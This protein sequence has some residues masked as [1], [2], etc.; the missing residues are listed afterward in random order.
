MKARIKGML[1]MG[2]LVEAALKKEQDKVGVKSEWTCTYSRDEI[3]KIWAKPPGRLLMPDHKKVKRLLE[4]YNGDFEEY[5]E[6][7]KA[8]EMR[9]KLAK[10]R[11]K[12]GGGPPPVDW[13]KSGGTLETDIDLRCREVQKEMDRAA[14]NSNPFMDSAVL[15]AA[16]Q[17]F[18]TQVLRL[19]L[20]REL[21]RL[22]REQVYER[23]RAQRFLVEDDSSEGETDNESSSDS[24]AEAAQAEAGKSIKDRMRLRKER[25]AKRR[26]EKLN[27]E[28][29]KDEVFEMKQRVMEANNKDD[30][31]QERLREL[32]A[33]GFGACPACHANPCR[34]EATVDVPTMQKRRR[35][36]SDEMHYI[37]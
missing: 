21:D 15:H 37:R 25:R 19:E 35:V 34:W 36:L 27:S 8:A 20:E 4:K 28:R 10:E 17:K 32:A 30:A 22:L 31:E 1:N 2:S 7:L 26:A 18:P 24:D 13:N 23:E 16:P 9:Q 14:H 11:E 3:L 12:R 5:S 6:W 33:L 29:L